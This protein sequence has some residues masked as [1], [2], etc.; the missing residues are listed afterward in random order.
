MP[1][2]R[3]YQTLAVKPG[4][5]VVLSIDFPENGTAAAHEI[6]LPGPNDMEGYNEIEESIGMGSDFIDDRVTI[7]TKA[8]NIDSGLPDVKVNFHINGNL[9]LEH[10]NAKSSDASPQIKLTISFIKA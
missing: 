3:Y 1:V 4:A 6:D 7:W 2:H 9:I 5:P 8:F 10:T